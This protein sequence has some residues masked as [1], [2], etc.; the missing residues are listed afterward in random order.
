M[1]SNAFMRFESMQIEIQKILF[2]RFIYFRKTTKTW[3]A[4]NSDGIYCTS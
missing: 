3:I 4:L 1:S 2:S